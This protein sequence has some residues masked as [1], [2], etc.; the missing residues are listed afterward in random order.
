[1]DEYS[2]TS[3]YNIRKIVCIFKIKLYRHF[4]IIFYDLWY[5]LQIWMIYLLLIDGNVTIDT[6]IQF[7]CL[8]ALCKVGDQV[9]VLLSVCGFQSNVNL[10]YQQT[11]TFIKCLERSAYID[12]DV[13]FFLKQ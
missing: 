6:F 10:S 3:L 5:I 13:A 4:P 2:R 7:I 11:C 1:M 8:F 9:R 12:P